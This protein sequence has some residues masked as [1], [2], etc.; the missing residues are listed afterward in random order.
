[1]EKQVQKQRMAWG[2]WESSRQPLT[3]TDKFIKAK[4]TVYHEKPS[5]IGESLLT[6]LFTF[7]SSLQAILK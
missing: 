4:F 2:V 6:S 7:F 1:M 5:D 3:I